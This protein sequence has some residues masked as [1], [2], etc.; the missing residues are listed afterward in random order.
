M[1]YNQP[2]DQPTNPNAP[3]VNG[4][5]QT[6]TQ[7]SI[8]PAASIE[9]PQREIVNVI[10]VAFNR[11]YKDF[12]E[13]PCNPP[14][15]IDLTQL[16]KAIEGFVNSAAVTVNTPNLNVY[17]KAAQATQIGQWTATQIS[18]LVTLN[19]PI[20]RGQNLSLSFNG[21]AIG[22]GGMDA[23]SMPLS[24]DISIYAI[25]NPTTNTWGTL[26]TFGTTSNGILYSG[27]NMP[28]GYT[29]S[30]L[31]FVGV[32]D[33]SRN[34]FTAEAHSGGFAW[35]QIDNRIWITSTNFLTTA[36]GAQT[37]TSISLGGLIPVAAKTVAGNGYVT[38]NGAALGGSPGFGTGGGAGQGMIG[39]QWWGSVSQAFALAANF[40]DIPLLNAVTVYYVAAAASITVGLSADSYTF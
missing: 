12:T 18:A 3:Y 32:T 17:G 4:N 15:N 1:Q 20:Y 6:G 22:A 19:G 24:G 31:L 14:E 30:R 2:F 7:G 9:F 29:A 34:F 33:S 36:A 35:Y 39:V 16:Q 8:P 10:Q 23:G 11:D 25:Y 26:G 38:N 27:G 37:P 28:A 13:T 21:A 5:P 40:A